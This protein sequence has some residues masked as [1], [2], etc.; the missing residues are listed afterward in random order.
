MD[1]WLLFYQYTRF[2]KENDLAEH[3]PEAA[4]FRLSQQIIRVTKQFRLQV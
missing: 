2:K 4:F 1:A 3:K